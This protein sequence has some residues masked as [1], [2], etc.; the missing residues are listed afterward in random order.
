MA[1]HAED[2]CLFVF[3]TLVFTEI[4]LSM[5]FGM[6]RDLYRC[7]STLFMAVIVYQ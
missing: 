6:A 4:T 2:F 7:V 1:A 3:N 5:T